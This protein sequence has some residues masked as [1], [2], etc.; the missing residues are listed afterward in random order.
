MEDVFRKVLFLFLDLSIL[1][2]MKLQ[3][4]LEAHLKL[5]LTSIWRTGLLRASIPL[6]YT[7]EMVKSKEVGYLVLSVLRSNPI[8]SKNT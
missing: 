4:I 8:E 7:Q 1:E 5:C 2:G 3:S 6:C